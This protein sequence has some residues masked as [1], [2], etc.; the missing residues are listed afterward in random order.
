MSL[1]ADPGH[2]SPH[3]FARRN[4]PRR[5]RRAFSR[6]ARIG[7]ILAAVAPAALWAEPAAARIAVNHNEA[8]GRD[9]R[10]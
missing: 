8:V 2:G 6:L 1:T 7:F 3:D 4:R 10:A 9:Q 5:P